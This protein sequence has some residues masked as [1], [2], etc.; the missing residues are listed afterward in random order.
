MTTCPFCGCDPFHY[1]DN[2]IGMEAVAVT[3]CEFGDLYFRGARPPIETTVMLEP[4]EFR[5]LGDKLLLLRAD[6]AAHAAIVHGEAVPVP[7]DMDHAKA[8][9]LVAERYIS[10]RVDTQ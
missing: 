1:V 2:G 10:D 6:A 3:C 9:L 7:A 8:M 5:E 4:D